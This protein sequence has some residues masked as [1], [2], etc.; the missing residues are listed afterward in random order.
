MFGW[1]RGLRAAKTR[2]VW[3]E[4]GA[5]SNKKWAKIILQER[6]TDLPPKTRCRIVERRGFYPIECRMDEPIAERLLRTGAVIT[7]R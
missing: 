1:L 6:R 4:I 5:G 7:Y 2:K 3:A